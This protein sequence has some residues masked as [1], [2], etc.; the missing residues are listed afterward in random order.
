MGT[1]LFKEDLKNGKSYEALTTQ[2]AETMWGYVDEV[3]APLT[4]QQLRSILLEDLRDKLKTTP[5]HDWT[6]VLVSWWLQAKHQVLQRCWT[7][8]TRG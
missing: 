3:V 1:L 5:D 2:N 6:G 4:S 7:R 8:R